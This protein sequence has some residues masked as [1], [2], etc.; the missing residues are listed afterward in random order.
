MGDNEGPDPKRRKKANKG[1]CRCVVGGCSNQMYDGF[2]IHECPSQ[3]GKTR[4]EWI[5]FIQ[6][7]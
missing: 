1:G 2:S 3:P 4:T 5:Q 7:T 6:S